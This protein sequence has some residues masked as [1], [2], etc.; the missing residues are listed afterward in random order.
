VVLDADDYKGNVTTMAKMLGTS[1]LPGEAPLQALRDRSGELSLARLP[2][3]ARPAWQDGFAP[4]RG[5]DVGTPPAKQ[6]CMGDHV[7]KKKKDRAE[8][9]REIKSDA[10]LARRAGRWVSDVHH[11]QVPRGQGPG[12]SPD[13][14]SRMEKSG[15]IPK[16][17]ALFR[18][19][20][21]GIGVAAG[22]SGIGAGINDM[23]NGNY[24][25]GGIGLA[26]GARTAGQGIAELTGKAGAASVLRKATPLVDGASAIN[27][28][29]KGDCAGA[30]RDGASTALGAFAPPHLAGAWKAGWGVEAPVRNASNRR[31]A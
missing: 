27:N 29:R 18:Q 22:F 2:D 6:S 20:L 31:T 5:V 12:Y 25:D 26:S 4:F 30:A 17:L 15:G 7:A 24:V 21:S 19:L 16:E 23:A 8:V 3:R 11:Y 9:F 1:P 14:V 28:L 10:D 13:E